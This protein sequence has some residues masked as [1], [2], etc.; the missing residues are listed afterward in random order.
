MIVTSWSLNR[1]GSW[2]LSGIECPSRT[3]IDAVRPGQGLAQGRTGLLQDRHTA[4]C[5][6]RPARVPIT[7]AAGTDPADWTPRELRRS[8]VSLLSDNGAS[9]NDVAALCGHAGTSVTEK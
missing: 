2:I 3:Q 9:I 5:R 4:R 1:R 7:A 6:Q 8:F